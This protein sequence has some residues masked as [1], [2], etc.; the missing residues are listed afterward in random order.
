MKILILVLISIWLVTCAPVGAPYCAVVP[1]RM[2]KPV[3]PQPLPPDNT[4]REK[5]YR[6]GVIVGSS[7]FDFQIPDWCREIK[8]EFDTKGEGI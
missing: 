2:E 6:C 5:A 4:L 3:P 8:N 1:Q 7:I